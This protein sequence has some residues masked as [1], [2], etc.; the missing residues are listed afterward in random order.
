MA[1]VYV[2]SQGKRI[3]SHSFNM[4]SYDSRHILHVYSSEE[5]AVDHIIKNAIY[6]AKVVA[7]R[8]EILPEVTDVEES[9]VTVYAM[10]HDEQCTEELYYID[11]SYDM[12]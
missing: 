5:K 11:E 6:R 2:V 1:K 9:M 3:I 7:N 4:S 8:Y 12:D 10:N